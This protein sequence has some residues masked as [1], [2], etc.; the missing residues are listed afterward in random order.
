MKNENEK[1]PIK[2]ENKGEI[3]VE[4]KVSTQKWEPEEKSYVNEKRLFTNAKKKNVGLFQ[5]ETTNK[6]VESPKTVNKTP[7]Q[8]IDIKN[9]AITIKGW[10]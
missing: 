6:Q 5:Q 2:K 1:S 3:I 10:E 8:L 7:E 4:N 9:N